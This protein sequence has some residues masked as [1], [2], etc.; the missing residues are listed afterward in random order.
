MVQQSIIEYVQGLLRQGYDPGTIRSTLLNAGYSPYD[1]DAA[2]RIAG[3]PGRHIETKT[4]VIIFAVIV[5]LAVV[6]LIVLKA[7]QPAPAVLSFD[8]NLFSTE[9]APGQDVVVNAEI[10]NPG[11]SKASGLIDYEITGPSGK[12]ASKT[13]SFSVLNQASV[14]TAISLPS[15]APLGSYSLVATLSYSGKQLKASR[16]FEVKKKVVQSAPIEALKERPVEAAK[17]VQLTC[18]GGCDDLDFCT[19]DACVS[20]VCVNTPI[21]PCCGNKVCEPGETADTCPLDCGARPAS[22]EEIISKAKSLAVSD[23]SGARAACDSLVLRPYV[24]SCLSSV[25]EV[26]DSKETCADIVDSAQRDSCYMPFAYKGD[27][28]VCEKLSNPYMKTA[29]VSLAELSKL[30]STMSKS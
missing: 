30:N 2:M 1:V 10:Q 6:V 18:P 25:S 13:E 22:T 3:A 24:D 26:A 5:A 9:V 11:G 15:T 16:T 20:G 23:L 8:V 17:A 28:S 7:M 29:C 12:I 4:L 19:T 21:V 27:F 14:P